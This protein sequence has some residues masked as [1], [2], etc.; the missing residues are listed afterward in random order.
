MT[1]LKTNY[2]TS[3]RYGGSLQVHHEKIWV[4]P[5]VRAA[6]FTSIV[7]R[8]PAY[9]LRTESGDTRKCPLYVAICL[10]A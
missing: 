4:C 3:R 9:L 8:A 7:T 1:P 2:S 5:P 10:G 6:Q